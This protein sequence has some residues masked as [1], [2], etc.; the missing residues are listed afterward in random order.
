[1]L[2]KQLQGCL[3][4]LKSFIN[5]NRPTIKKS[6]HAAL[7]CL[8][9]A[10]THTVGSFKPLCHENFPPS[11]VSLYI[12][13]HPHNVFPQPSAFFTGRDMEEDRGGC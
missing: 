1:M 6:S 10:Q 12:H 3:K 4:P 2:Y 5:L 11:R 9:H 13:S 8:C 7:F